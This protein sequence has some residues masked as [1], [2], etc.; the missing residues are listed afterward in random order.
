LQANELPCNCSALL[1]Y[2]KLN[3]AWTITWRARVERPWCGTWSRDVLAPLSNYMRL[4][5]LSHLVLLSNLTCAAGCQVRGMA[6]R[7]GAA[8]VLQLRRHDQAV[9]QRWRRLVLRTNYWRCASVMLSLC[10]LVAIDK[11]CPRSAAH[12]ATARDV[13][14]NCKALWYHSHWGMEIT[15]GH[16]TWFHKLLMDLSVTCWSMDWHKRPGSERRRAATSP[17][18]CV[19]RG[20]VGWLLG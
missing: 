17:L 3:C 9:G 16:T 2:L 10:G 20:N 14:S 8:G 1:L 11:D 7:G 5:M 18:Q 12:A 6:P 13:L 4:C 19:A 15:R